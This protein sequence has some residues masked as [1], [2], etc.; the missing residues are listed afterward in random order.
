M[1]LF[2]IKRLVSPTVSIQG[3]I[4]V[5]F[6]LVTLIGIVAVTSIVYLYMRETVKNNAITSV[7]DSIRQADESVNL[8]LEEISRLNTVVVTNQTVLQ[9]LQSETVE[10]SYDW[11]QEQKRLEEFLSAVIAYKS[12]ITRVAVVGLNGKVFFVGSPWLDRS[13]LHTPVMDALLHNESGQAYYH[14]TSFGSSIVTGREIRY[15]RKTLGI[16]MFDLNDD[17]IRKTY[18]VKPT[19]DSMIYV[20]DEKN[21]FIY[22]P[23]SSGL[24]QEAVIQLNRELEGGNTSFERDIN[25]K[26]YLVVSRKSAYTGWSTL[27]LVPMESLLSET[28]KIRKVLVTVAIIV[29]LIIVIVTSQV[30]SRITRNIR[31]L[32]SMMMRVMEGNLT[33]PPGEIYS[34]DEI[35]HLYLVFKRMVE[36]LKRLLEG[37]MTTER[38]KREAELAV[39]QAQIRPHF[40]YNSLNTVKYLAKLNGVPNIVEVSE[41]LIELM[42]GVLGHT[43]EYLTLGEELQYVRSYV[44]IEKYKY[45]EPLRLEIEV[46]DQELL[47]CKVL[48]LMLQ[49]I[50]ENAIIHGI[51]ASEQDGRVTVR[52]Y[53]E[54]GELRIDVRD[55]GQGMTQEQMDALL[56]V[57]KDQDNT[58]FSGMGVRNV[59]ERIVRLYGERYGVFLDSELGAYTNVQIRFPLLPD[60]GLKIQGE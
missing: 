15:N 40:L 5:A 47:Q 19:S 4:F 56:E 28:V 34:K 41:S 27:A 58:R 29:F 53:K 13:V 44:T 16:V 57:K 45:V 33:L 23:P 9:T 22:Q 36:E 52:I 18:D 30:S 59:H 51:A 55:N 26:S 46:A 12:F 7:Q 3:K 43:N 50:V 17:F 42:R 38:E 39:L 2:S 49:P 60:L 14:Q 20:V 37:I 25:K 10:P 35:G 21:E 11:F 24:D 6:S 48:K 1:K 8:R 54:N 31:K 32:R